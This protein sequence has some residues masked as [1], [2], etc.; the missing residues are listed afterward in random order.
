MGRY[1]H[2]CLF[3]FFDC[4]QNSQGLRA[5]YFALLFLSA[6]LIYT[7]KPR[8]QAHAH[9]CAHTHTLWV[10]FFTAD[11]IQVIWSKFQGDLIKFSRSGWLERG[12][13]QRTHLY[14]TA[15]HLNWVPYNC[16]R[17]M[18]KFVGPSACPGERAHDVISL[19]ILEHVV[20]ELQSPD[21]G[22]CGHKLTPSLPHV[23]KIE[24]FGC[25][26]ESVLIPI[27]FY[28]FHWELR[29]PFEIKEHVVQIGT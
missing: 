24:H 25:S 4:L 28:V 7:Q 8:K 15:H 3:L 6:L 19:V 17:E 2:I 26:C 16:P 23:S 22:Y 11:W 29:F 27:T 5:S 14:H 10:I 1:L 18:R 9:A 20:L 21:F 13:A 12:D